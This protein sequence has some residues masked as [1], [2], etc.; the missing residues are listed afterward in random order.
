MFRVI[1]AVDI[2]SGKCVQLQ[3]GDEK[4]KIIEIDDVVGVAKGWVE[5]G[6]KILHLIDLDGSFR[7]RLVHENLILEI[8]RFVDVQVG[9]GIR[10]SKT[11]ENLLNKGIRKVII[12]TLAVKNP[13]EVIKLAEKYPNRIII[14][15]DSRKGEVVVKGW[16]ESSKLSPLD[17]AKIYEDCDV[18]FLYTNVDVEGLMRGVDYS[19]IKNVVENIGKPVIVAGGVSTA[20]DV[21]RIKEIGAKGVVI[22]SALY[23]GKLNF[24]DI[25]K[26]EE[27]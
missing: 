24:E 7:G 5:K 18:E 13:D 9:G 16:R 20:K 11:A 27:E 6:A 17:L 10:D 26:L 25:I 21:E 2:K 1:P 23:T 12:G 15:I 14:A 19:S 22:G 4:R 8:S 3:Q